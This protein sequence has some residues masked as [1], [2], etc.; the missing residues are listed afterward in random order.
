MSLK[1]IILLKLFISF[2]EC[3][4]KFPYVGALVHENKF[5]GV[6][7]ILDNRNLIAEGYNTFASA[8]HFANTTWKFGEKY[9]IVQTLMRQLGPVSAVMVTTDRNIVFSKDIQPIAKDKLGEIKVG[10]EGVASGWPR[11]NMKTDD[12]LDDDQIHLNLTVTECSDYSS[13]L[14]SDY[15][16]CARN[17][18]SYSANH[19]EVGHVFV[20]N[21]TLIGLLHTTVYN[22]DD[23]EYVFQKVS[24]FYPWI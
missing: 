2:V 5:V 8:V 1:V 16:F 13:F 3:E 21:N 22:W 11:K 23:T 15:A 17:M 12:E 10:Q 14:Y 18:N 9:N 6:A 4:N 20:V 24:I 19:A 7:A